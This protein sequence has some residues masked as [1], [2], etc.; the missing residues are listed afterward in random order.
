MEPRARVTQEDLKAVLYKVEALES[1]RDIP[2][3]DEELIPD[4]IVEKIPAA[5]WVH[6]LRLLD[7]I[8]Y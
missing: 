2:P 5:G 7:S 3:W 6:N 8:Y 1:R 4:D